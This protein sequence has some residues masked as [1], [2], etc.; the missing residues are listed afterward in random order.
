MN[1]R[2]HMGATPEFSTTADYVQA[3]MAK[4]LGGDR[5]PAQ[6]QKPARRSSEDSAAREKIER[7]AREA[8]AR[9]ES[10]EWQRYL[11]DPATRKRD[12]RQK[13]DSYRRI[14]AELGS[15]RPDVKARLEARVAEIENALTEG[16]VPELREATSRRRGKP[17]SS[18]AARR[19]AEE[20]EY[21]QRLREVEARWKAAGRELPQ[22]TTVEIN[23]LRGGDGAAIR[24]AR[25]E[26][27][28]SEEV[29]AGLDRGDYSL[30]ERAHK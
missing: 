8:Q 4:R 3:E 11:A 21:E 1:T 25:I 28:F 27:A 24:R 6:K 15:D 17:A 12:A 20:Q 2:M 29:I 26:K 5:R 18:A 16:R 10:A 9:R 13:A 7:E 30:L 23:Q 14:I 22:L 19:A